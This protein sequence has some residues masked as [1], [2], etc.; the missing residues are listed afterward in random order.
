MFANTIFL[1]TSSARFPMFM[2]KIF[3]F[4]I[5]LCST[6][7][8]SSTFRC[9]GFGVRDLDVTVPAPRPPIIVFVDHII[10]SRRVRVLL[11]RVLARRL[12]LLVW[13]V[14]VKM[15]G[16]VRVCGN[17][18]VPFLC[19]LV[20]RCVLGGEDTSFGGWWELWSGI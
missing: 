10:F 16:R 8:F 18:L 19:L 14:L 12:W 9:E 1:A 3:D 15:D 17:V 2:I 7:Q 13:S 11:F 5:L 20:C 6:F 4:C